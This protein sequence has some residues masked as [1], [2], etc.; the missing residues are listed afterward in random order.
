MVKTLPAVAG[1]SF[2]NSTLTPGLAPVCSSL[3]M[4]TG[5]VLPTILYP[6]L[7]PGK[8][9]QRLEVYCGLS[10]VASAIVCALLGESKK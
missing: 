2:T 4:V 8:D 6:V 10:G 1:L 5:A 3:V 7:L 9:N